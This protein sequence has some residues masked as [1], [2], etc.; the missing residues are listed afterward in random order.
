MTQNKRTAFTLIEI[1]IVVLIIG[2]LAAI[3][4]P[5]FQI[6][7]RNAR[8]TRLLNDFRVIST[9]VD[10]YSQSTGSYPPDSD[11]GVAP[12][13]ITGYLNPFVWEETP[14]IGGQWDLEGEGPSF[15][16]AFGVIDY[17]MSEAD[18]IGFD[19]KYDDGSFV[20]GDYQKIAAN[21]Y[22]RIVEH[23]D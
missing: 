4:I 21:R 11:P 2:L 3:A 22:Y 10:I 12:P 20:T 7:S 14:V 1:M 18:L 8:Y 9:A 15:L 13:E 6:A 5:A 16:C 19:R 17:N 23:K